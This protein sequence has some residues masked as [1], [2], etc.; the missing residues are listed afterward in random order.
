MTY[1]QRVG[2]SIPSA[3]TLIIKGLHN[4]RPFFAF[5]RFRNAEQMD[6]AFPDRFLSRDLPGSEK[7][8]GDS[9]MRW[10]QPG[11]TFPLCVW[12]LP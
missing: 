5:G 1:K 10:E 11:T 12:P 3:P 6:R 2:G 7:M 4:V 9:L 8:Q